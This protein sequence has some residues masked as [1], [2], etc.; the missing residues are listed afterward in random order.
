MYILCNFIGCLLNRR[1]ACLND[2]VIIQTSQGLAQY[3]LE[4][5]KARSESGERLVCS[6]CQRAHKHFSL[7]N[8]AIIVGCDRSRRSLQLGPLVSPLRL[9]LPP[10]RPRRRPLL[11]HLSDAMGA[12][13]RSAEARGRRRGHGHR[14]A[15]PQGGQRV[16]G[17][18]EQRASSTYS[19]LT[20]LLRVL[21]HLP[22]RSDSSS[23]QH[24]HPEFDPVQPDSRRRPRFLRRIL[25]GGLLG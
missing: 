20:Y 23:T 11:L 13:H 1:F 4:S 8:Y 6:L 25:S 16:Q 15:Q 22:S 10:R 24:Q 17:L 19:S 7:T 3:L 18:L 2:L 12:V 14:I 21:P 9:R 5:N